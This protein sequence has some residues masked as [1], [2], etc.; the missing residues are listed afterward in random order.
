MTKQAEQTETSEQVLL[1]YVEMCYSVALALTRDPNRAEG[2]ARSVLAEAWH[3][4]D[5]VLDKKDIK[6]NLLTA[7][8]KNFLNDHCRVDTSPSLAGA[9]ALLL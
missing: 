3:L 1:S 9:V 2:L 4:R 8:R 5:T 7:L 6:R